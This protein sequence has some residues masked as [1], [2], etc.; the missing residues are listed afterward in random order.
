M[1]IFDSH[2]HELKSEYTNSIQTDVKTSI[3]DGPRILKYPR[4]GRDNSNSGRF[5]HSY[6]R[7]ME[8]MDSGVSCSRSNLKRPT[9]QIS[10]KVVSGERKILLEGDFERDPSKFWGLLRSLSLR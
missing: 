4:W 5:D 2:S 6:G 9:P 3:G 1:E 8:L 7:L 10:R